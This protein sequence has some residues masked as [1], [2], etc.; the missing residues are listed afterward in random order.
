MKILPVTKG[1]NRYCGPAVI[2]ALTGVDTD[3]A[4]RL[5]RHYTGKRAVKGTG[6][7]SIKQALYACGIYAL[8]I[9]DYRTSKARPTLAGWLK[10][11]KS[12]RTP[13]KV[14]LIAAGN[15][16][17]LVSGRRYVCGLTREVVSIK[18]EKVRRRARVSEVIVLSSDGIKIPTDLIDAMKPQDVT[19]RRKA[20]ALAKEW[21]IEIEQDFDDVWSVWP[22]EGLFDPDGDDPRDPF[23]GERMSSDWHEILGM[24]IQYVELV[25]NGVPE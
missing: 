10:E 9:A 15:H 3:D 16:W 14:F 5:I 22:P 12:L 8:T 6:T 23:V 20:R 18:H 24:V 17:Q 21:G 25:K 1:K 13:G 7:R 4:A 11:N 2:S 19:E